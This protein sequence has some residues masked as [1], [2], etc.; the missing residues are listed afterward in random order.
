MCNNLL[1]SI[2]FVKLTNNQGPPL[3]AKS[4]VISYA[5]FETVILYDLYELFNFL[6]EIT[7]DHF[8]I[9]LSDFLQLII[10]FNAGLF[11]IDDTL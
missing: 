10:Y 3:F 5:V 6:D 4:P 11:D 1:K 9:R 8:K 7:D 2:F